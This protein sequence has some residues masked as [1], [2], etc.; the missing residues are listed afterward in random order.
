[1]CCPD[2]N[3]VIIIPALN[4]VLPNLRNGIMIWNWKIVQEGIESIL[5]LGRVHPFCPEKAP[6]LLSE[7][8]KKPLKGLI[9]HYDILYMET[10]FKSRKA[11]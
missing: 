11:T 6:A 4:Q 10:F 7:L 8:P 3:I 1:M 9:D 5:I 2:P